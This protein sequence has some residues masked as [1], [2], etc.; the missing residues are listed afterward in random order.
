MPIELIRRPRPDVLIK[1]G[2]YTIA[3]VVGAE[4]VQPGGGGTGGAGRSG[5][6]SIN[7]GDYPAAGIPIAGLGRGRLAR[8]SHRAA[9]DVGFSDVSGC[10]SGFWGR[11]PGVLSLSGRG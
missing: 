8:I 10:L 11:E 3:T 4:E 9:A 5:R 1:G 6:W 2:D 7:D